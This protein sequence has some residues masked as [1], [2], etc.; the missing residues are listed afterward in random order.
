MPDLP[1]I[2]SGSISRAEHDGIIA[3]GEIRSGLDWVFAAP[4]KLRPL[5]GGS[6]GWP[7]LL[8]LPYTTLPPVVTFPTRK[9]KRSR[10]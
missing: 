5:S 1:S 2:L 7:E 3:P 9:G 10:G 4:Q 6:L 8:F